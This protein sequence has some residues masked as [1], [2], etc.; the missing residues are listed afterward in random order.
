MAKLSDKLQALRV[1]PELHLPR[2]NR[3]PKAAAAPKPG[4]SSRR[5]GGPSIPRLGPEIKLPKLT[6][7]RTGEGLVGL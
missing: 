1:G 6:R 2:R 3:T 5:P 4:R 7:Q